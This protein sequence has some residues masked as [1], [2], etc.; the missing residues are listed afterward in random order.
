VF[1]Q[2]FGVLAF[3]GLVAPGVVFELLREKRRPSLEE[4]AF[5]EASRIA[6]TSLVFTVLAISVLS[7]VRLIW[8]SALLDPADWLSNGMTYVAAHPGLMGRSLVLELLLAIGLA[9]ATD[10]YLRRSAPGQIVGGSIWFQTFRRRRPEGTT[11]WVHVKLD[12]ETEL[13]GY[14]GDYTSDPDLAKRE[15]TLTGPK[16]RYR[17]KGA[18]ADEHLDS[19]SS[20]SLRGDKISWMKVAYVADDSP[21]DSP[22]LVAPAQLRERWSLRPR[23]R[24]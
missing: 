2:T 24:D 22:R 13:W 18:T 20:V 17:R 1:T 23:W 3:F 9:V 7:V 21:P 12:D 6:L 10:W 8:Q 15:L 19:W 5:R 14:V 4:T 11:P 16:L